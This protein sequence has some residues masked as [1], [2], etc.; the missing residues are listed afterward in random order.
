MF[1]L[2]RL[3]SRSSVALSVSIG[4]V[5]TG[6]GRGTAVRSHSPDDD[7]CHHAA[8]HRFF[9]SRTFVQIFTA[10]IRGIRM[11]SGFLDPGSRA[12]GLLLP[13]L[14]ESFHG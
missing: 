3:T 5:R 12:G 6:C 8:R 11:Q 10:A 4:Y 13:C 9:P 2:A 1:I 7:V 14:K